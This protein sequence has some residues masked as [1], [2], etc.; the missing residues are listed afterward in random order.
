M[1][2]VPTT[3]ACGCGGSGPLLARSPAWHCPH[4]GT[5]YKTDGLDPSDVSHQ[6][7]I[8]KRMAWAGVIAVLALVGALAFVAPA[9]LIATP[10]LLAAYYYSILPWYRRRLRG[11]YAAL[12]E[13]RLLPQ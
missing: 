11:I 9:V 7:A 10:A 12:P 3:V 4:C 13:W 2:T 5:A 8:V 6:L 1:R